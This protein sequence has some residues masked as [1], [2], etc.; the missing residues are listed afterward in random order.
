M[1]FIPFYLGLMIVLFNIGCK[2]GPS[3]KTTNGFDYKIINDQ[4]GTAIQ[5]GDY[6]YF[7]YSVYD[8]EKLLF[9][10]RANKEF[11]KV[12]M[13]SIVKTDPKNAQ[14]I[15]ELISLMSAGDSGI[16]YQKLS[17]EFKQK[18]QLPETST[19]LKFCVTLNEVKTAAQYEEEEKIKAE[20]QKAK[21]AAGQARLVEIEATMKTVLAD[22]KSGKNKSVVKTTPSGL[23][24]IIHKEGEGANF[25]SGN[26]V[27]VNYYGILASNGTKFDDSW[28]RGEP[29]TFVLGKGQVIPGWD[30]GVALMKKG[31]AATLFIP[32]KLGYGDQG[33]G[34]AIPPGA[35]LVFYIEAE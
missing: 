33:A 3:S 9:D 18:L 23:K 12:K 5:V 1:K 34:T 22:Y 16:V 2:S 4:A 28:S 35:E 32:A 15:T 27:T 14:P 31:G 25:A 26:D 30:E 10:S 19:E 13:D 17:P 21:A 24:Y 6:A 11:A 8:G 20:K 7:H 29:F